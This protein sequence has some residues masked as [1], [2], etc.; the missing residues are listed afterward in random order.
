MANVR[1]K[2]ETFA[3][4]GVIRDRAA[5]R[6]WPYG[7]GP[8]V[9]GSFAGTHRQHYSTLD[10]QHVCDWLNDRDAWDKASGGDYTLDMIRKRH[11]P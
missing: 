7:L 10:A 3:E 6:V 11:D 9:M 5:V 8:Y 2:T 1:F 4:V